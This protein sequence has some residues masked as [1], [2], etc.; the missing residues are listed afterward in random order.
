MVGGGRPAR[1]WRPENP[2]ISL[3]RREAEDIGRERSGN[4]VS[5][6]ASSVDKMG[7]EA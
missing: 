5:V 6:S 4:S 1:K 7:S 3:E 2:L